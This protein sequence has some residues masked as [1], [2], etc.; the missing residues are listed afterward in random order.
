MSQALN[1]VHKVVVTGTVGVPL[2]TLFK[3]DDF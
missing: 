3:V 1:V 2:S